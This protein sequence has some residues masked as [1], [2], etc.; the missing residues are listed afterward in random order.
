VTVCLSGEGGD[1]VFI[2]YDRFIASKADRLYRILPRWF[3]RGVIEPLVT[4]LPD[5]EQK[6][7][8]LVVMRRFVEGVAFP[9]DPAGLFGFVDVP[10]RAG[11]QLLCYRVNELSAGIGRTVI[12]LEE[13]RHELENAYARAV[14]AEGNP[15]AKAML[16]DVF[17]VTDRTWRGIGM[18]PRSGWKLSSRYAEFDAETRFSVTDIPGKMPR[19]SGA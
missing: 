10:G 15:A 6:K 16:L 9:D 7:G 11:L 18:I 19:P 3:R 8:P 13:G 17:E 4:R 5:Q 2:G 12:Q 1:E 14:P